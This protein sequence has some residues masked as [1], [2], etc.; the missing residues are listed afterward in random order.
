MPLYYC[1][2]HINLLMIS[3]RIIMFF[4]HGSRLYCVHGQNKAKIHSD[5]GKAVSLI[6][7]YSWRTILKTFLKSSFIFTQFWVCVPPWSNYCLWY[8]SDL[9]RLCGRSRTRG[10]S[11]CRC[12]CLS[13]RPFT[14][15]PARLLKLFLLESGE[16]HDILY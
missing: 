13:G 10:W 14:R 1:V 3:H 8:I 4:S 11:W 16:I 5:E 9:S 7:I 15:P 6:I 2:I 12:C